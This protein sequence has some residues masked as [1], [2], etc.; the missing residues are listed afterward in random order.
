[1][2]F[3]NENGYECLAASFWLR[4]DEHQQHLAPPR[5]QFCRRKAYFSEILT[6]NEIICKFD[7]N[8]NFSKFSK[9]TQNFSK[10]F[11]KIEIFRKFAKNRN[12]STIWLET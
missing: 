2:R 1:M 6:K 4:W 3:H 10:I 8:R 11:P 7:P 12:F 9:K 5:G